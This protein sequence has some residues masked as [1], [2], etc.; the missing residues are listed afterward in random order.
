MPSMLP[1]TSPSIFLPRCRFQS[2]AHFVFFSVGEEKK[3]GFSPKK[4]FLH[5]FVDQDYFFGQHFF[6]NLGKRR[7]EFQTGCSRA[8]AQIFAKCSLLLQDVVV[9][10]DVVDDILVLLCCCC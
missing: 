4:F 10:H 6:Q 5:F 8:A 7:F 1:M 3:V 2:A 9:V